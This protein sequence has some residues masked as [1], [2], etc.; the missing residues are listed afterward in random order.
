MNRALIVFGLLFFDA[1]AQLRAS[2]AGD[3]V[4]VVYNLHV[5][6]SKQVADYY[7]RKRGVPSSQVFGFSLP[8]SESIS[9]A[10]F[11]D[12]LQKPLAESLK[13][14]KL[15]HIGSCTVTSGTNE[16]S[17]VER[18]VDHPP[19][20]VAADRREQQGA[21]LA[22]IGIADYAGAECAGQHHDQPEQDLGEALGRVEMAMEE[23]CHSGAAA[24]RADLP[25]APRETTNVSQTFQPS[26]RFWPA[27]S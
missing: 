14:K 22:L 15:W 3:E 23:R 9:R 10:D 24:G 21:C 16:V 1:S 2:G 17:H 4:V 11:R 19:G 13:S 27:N 7:A 18:R 12:L 6:E 25:D 5:P 26:G 8:T 20:D